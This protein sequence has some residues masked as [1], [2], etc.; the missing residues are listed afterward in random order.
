MQEGDL[1]ELITDANEDLAVEYKAWMDT[2]TPV[3]RAK[4]ARHIA[5]LANH[6]GGYLVFGVD[7]ATR[8]PMGETDL[9]RS[10]FSQEA[11]A[12]II[13]KY[14]DPRVQVTVQAAEVEN[15]SYPV[16]V[17]QSHGARPVIAVADGIPDANGKPLGVVAGTIYMR[18]AGPQSTAIRTGDDWNAL[19]DRC[20]SHRT[21]LLGVLFR[22]SMARQS[23]PSRHIAEILAAVVD[24]AAVDFRVT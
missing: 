3:A 20:L 12:S 9:A 7:D 8:K 4:L 1:V 14:L 10:L 11:F 21:D 6:G 17:V 2:S 22:Q 5:A 19:L 13:K 18:A 16:I 24:E 15:V 23:R